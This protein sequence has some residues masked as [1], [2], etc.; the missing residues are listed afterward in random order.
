M[1]SDGPAPVYV[2]DDD[3]AMRDSLQVLL[4]TEGLEARTFASGEAFL[5]AAETIPDGLLVLDLHMPSVGGLEVLDQLKARRI[6]MP[7]VVITGRL[8]DAARARALSAGVTAILEKPLDP[9]TLL[10]TLRRM[11]A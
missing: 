10:Q 7:A 5:R 2:V 3:D 9:D 8:D 4:A 6:A 11:R 1:H